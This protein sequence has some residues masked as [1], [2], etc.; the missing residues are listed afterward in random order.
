MIVCPQLPLCD[1]S[2]YNL[3][4]DPH[5]GLHSAAV[6][7]N[8]ALVRYALDHGQP[9][10]SALDGV[11]PLHAACSGG[12]D[13]VVRLLIE[14]GADVNA[15]RSVLGFHVKGSLFTYPSRNFPTDSLEDIRMTNA[16]TTLRLLSA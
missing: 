1:L 16:A 8:I 15:P 14:N 6:T 9:I 12:N 3:F 4:A 10:N 5:L 7:G 11:L 13:F 2:H